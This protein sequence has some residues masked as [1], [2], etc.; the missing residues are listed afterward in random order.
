MSDS[1][2]IEYWLDD[3]TRTAIEYSEYWNDA[4]LEREKPWDVTQ[5]GFGEVESYLLEV[6][7]EPDLHMCV[8]ELKRRTGRDLG[9]RGIDIAAGTLWAVPILLRQPGVEHVCCLEYSRHRLLD[10]GP[11]MLE[12]YGVEPEQVTLALGS[13]YDLKIS[14]ASL[15]FAFLSQALHHAD[16]PDALLAELHR[17]LR[18]DGVV[19]FT[20]HPSGADLEPPEPT[21]GDHTYTKSEYAQLFA[22]AGFDVVQPRRARAHYQSFVLTKRAG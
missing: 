8:N 5:R 10:L 13:F 16:Q 22:G 1:W 21:L 11:T 9:A 7:L 20:L 19:P 15:D 4:E 18:P 6:G 17:V 12:H 3:D 2:H 14:D